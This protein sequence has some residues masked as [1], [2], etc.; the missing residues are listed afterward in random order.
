[1]PHIFIFQ[2]STGRYKINE[3]DSAGGIYIFVYKIILIKK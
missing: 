3:M 2:S 1:M